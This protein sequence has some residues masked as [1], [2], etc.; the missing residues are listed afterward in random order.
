MLFD[1]DGTLAESGQTV[2]PGIRAIWGSLSAYYEMGVVG[3][4]TFEK[5]SQQVDG[6]VLDHCFSECGCVYHRRGILR[7]VKNIRDH[8]VYPYIDRLV[9]KTLS[10]LATVEYPLSGH[11]IDV[12]HGLVYIS[13][14]G[15]SATTAER[16][17]FFRVDATRLPGTIAPYASRGEGTS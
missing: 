7:Y 11:L 4:G 8:I 3:G 9:K 14:V 1:V 5:I 2:H 15:L 12:R 10:F 13:L 17:A 16:D 6:L